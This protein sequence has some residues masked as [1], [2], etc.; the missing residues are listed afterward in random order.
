MN[1]AC[2][3]FSRLPDS[4]SSDGTP[5]E[6]IE[7]RTTSS[8]VLGKKGRKARKGSEAISLF[9]AHPVLSMLGDWWNESISNRELLPRYR[10]D[11]EKEA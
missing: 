11:C 3:S 5:D 10:F 2:D 4:P 7:E 9:Q 6:T 1:S 8:V